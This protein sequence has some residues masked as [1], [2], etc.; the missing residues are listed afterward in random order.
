VVESTFP[1]PGTERSNSSRYREGLPINIIA[2][3]VGTSV[4]QV[5]D[6]IAEPGRARTAAEQYRRAHPEPCYKCSEA[7]GTKRIGQGASP[8][9]SNAGMVHPSDDHD[10]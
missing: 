2:A 6:W 9:I 3:E 10:S 8:G 1:T 7:V 5:R 4:E